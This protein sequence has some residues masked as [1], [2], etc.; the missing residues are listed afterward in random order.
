MFWKVEVGAA[1]VVAL[2]FLAFYFGMRI[3]AI[4]NWITQNFNKYQR[5]A[6]P[7]VMPREEYVFSR[8][9][10][11]YSMLNYLP[12]VILMV[13]P[14]SL[15]LGGGL[16]TL[17]RIA[18]DSPEVAGR[19]VGDI[20]LANIVG[21][22]FGTLTISFILLPTIGSE[23][24]LK[25][26]MVLGLIFLGLYLKAKKE[27]GE[28]TKIGWQTW[29]AGA[30]VLLL[31][32]ILPGK[33]QF[34]TRLY[35]TANQR[36]V[37]VRETSETVL[38]LELIPENLSPVRLW[39]GGETNSVFPGKGAFEG[40][41]MAC[42]GASQPKR[43]L[44]IGLGGGNSAYFYSTLPGVEKIVIVEL[45]PDLAP[46]LTDH[47]EMTRSLLSNPRVHYI[48]DDG[49]RY[50]YAHPDEKYDLI[51]L[52]PVRN[53]TSGHNSLYSVE[54]LELYQIHLTPTGILCQWEDEWNVLP[55]TVATIFP[56]VDHYDGFAIAS[57][58]PIQY[59]MEYMNGAKVDFAELGASFVDATTIQATDPRNVFERFIRDRGQIL[60]EEQGTPI[61]KDFSPWLEYYLFHKPKGY[62]KVLTETTLTSYINRIHGCDTSCQ[63]R[64]LR[65]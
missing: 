53:F 9:A 41:A 31:L 20:H 2:V 62:T 50:L 14:A 28:D 8:W 40:Q 29:A 45:I 51:S 26:L 15:I 32:A 27:S 58:Q 13:L 21:S 10:L 63:Q 54:A 46:F 18:I 65:K 61:L 1:V 55:K 25:V 4:G 5:P 48:S 35:E 12:P 11:F 56:Y 22:V 7:M 38:A 60:D 34:Y 52:D 49:R 17:D 37:I 19:R 44:V 42:A 39:I 23:L 3:P 16:P 24:T 43:V 59:D 6:S 57:N 33:G 30:S 36:P 47:I 64:I